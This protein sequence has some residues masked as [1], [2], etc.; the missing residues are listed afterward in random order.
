PGLFHQVAPGVI[1]P[2]HWP[3]NDCTYMHD[4]T[5]ADPVAEIQCPQGAANQWPQDRL[6]GLV[7]GLPAFIA[8]NEQ[9]Q[10]LDA[11]Q[12][13]LGINQ[14]YPEVATFIAPKCTTDACG[15][16]QQIHST[17]RCNDLCSGQGCENMDNNPVIQNLEAQFG[18]NPA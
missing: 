1:P 7:S 11:Q 18:N 9:L 13:T 3:Y 15:Q 8:L 17:Q 16:L 4:R 6:D 14:W 2:K 12:L 10:G 5:A